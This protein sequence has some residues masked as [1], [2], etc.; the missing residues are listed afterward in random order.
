MGPLMNFET[1]GPRVTL[2]ADITNERFCS[3]V[4]KLMSLKMTL[5][6]ESFVA[7]IEGACKWPFTG[8]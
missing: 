6:D 5:G 7:V 8:L 3:R 4:D 2:S 1:A